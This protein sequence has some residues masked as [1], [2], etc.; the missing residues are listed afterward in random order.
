MCELQPFLTQKDD[1]KYYQFKG[2]LIEAIVIMSVSVGL[3]VFREH[4]DSLI[5]ALLTIQDIIFE[6]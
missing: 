3:E 1:L 4:A 6:E 5:N 2:Q